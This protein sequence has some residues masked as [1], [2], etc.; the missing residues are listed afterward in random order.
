[1]CFVEKQMFSLAFHF[2]KFAPS[3]WDLQRKK[4]HGLGMIAHKQIPLFPQPFLLDSGAQGT[5]KMKVNCAHA[6]TLMVWW[7]FLLDAVFA[8]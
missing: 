5:F 1:M 6:C 4:C 7:Q 3:F 2:L 8:E